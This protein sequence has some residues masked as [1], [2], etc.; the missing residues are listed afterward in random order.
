[1][2]DGLAEEGIKVPTSNVVYVDPQTSDSTVVAKQLG[3]D[4]LTAH[5]NA[6]HVLFVGANEGSAQGLL[7]AVET[8]NR[9]DDAI[10]VS[11]DLTDMGISN[12]YM[13]DNVWIGST[14]F[15]PENYGAVLVPMVQ[16][17]LAGKKIDLVQ[18]AEI[19]FVDRSNIREFYPDPNK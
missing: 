1:V 9:E 7:S 5:P 14:A 3:T 12:L 19:Q 13:E 4:F 11:I 2:I 10:V 6:A 16:D 8:S 17:I 18:P 15:F